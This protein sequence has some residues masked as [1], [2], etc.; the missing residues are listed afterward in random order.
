LEWTVPYFK[1][2]GL[3]RARFD[4]EMLLASSLGVD[5]LWLYTH[6][7]QPLT[8]PELDVFRSAVI[9]RSKREPL[10]YILGYW[11]F[12]ALDFAVWPGVL[13][14]R[15]ETEHLVECALKFAGSANKILDLCTGSGNIA[16]SLAKELPSTFFWATDVSAQAVK[17]AMENARKHGIQ[18]RICFLCGDLFEPV[19]GQEKSFDLIVCNPPYIPTN[20]INKLQ[21]EIKDFEP[22]LAVDGGKDGLS[23]Y[24]RLIPEAV[25]FLKPSGCLIMEIGE[26]QARPGQE[27][28]RNWGYQ[29]ITVFK[30]YG[31]LDRVLVGR[32]P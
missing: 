28:M 17:L 22:R 20:Q 15:Q 13:I 23:F 12:W 25:S 1:D 30:D 9:R 26:N 18:Q 11:G 4:S 10:Q 2:L 21:P 5:R 14:P 16:I 8:G 19:K 7:D 27:M 32:L 3:E 6:F 29:E 31:G 24:R